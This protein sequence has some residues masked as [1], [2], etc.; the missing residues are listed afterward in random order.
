MNSL[1]QL[2]GLVAPS[3]VGWLVDTYGSWKL[4]LLIQATCYVVAGA[5]WL[6]MDAEKPL[7]AES[8]AA[9]VGGQAGIEVRR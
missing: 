8:G 4:P 9:I 5:F 2:G 3:V 1:G 7:A 6:L